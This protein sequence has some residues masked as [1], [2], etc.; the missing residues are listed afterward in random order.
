MPRSA[1]A[2]RPRA[3]TAPATSPWEARAGR[4][5]AVDFFAGAGGWTTAARALGVEVELS[6]NHWDVAVATHIANHP[7]TRHLCQDVNLVNWN[8]VPRT[9][10]FISSPSC[11][12]HAN[13]RGSDQPRHDTARATAWVVIDALTYLQPRM[14]VVEN[15]PEM[16]DDWILWDAWKLAVE[17]LGYKF[18]I[19]RLDAAEFG[20]AQHRER[21]FIV[22]TRV[23]KPPTIV[24][25]RLPL[26]PARAILDLDGG[27]WSP[28]DEHVEAT[29]ARA[30]A[31]RAAHGRTFVMPYYGSGSGLTGRSLDR[32]L[33]T[34]TTRDRW[35]IVRGRDMR[36]LHHGENGRA[37]GFPEGYKMAGDKKEIMQQFGNAV[38]PHQ[39]VEV[40][41]QMLGAAPGE[42]LRLAARNGLRCWADLG[43]A[44]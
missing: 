10:L 44:A 40:L 13:A 9:E 42:G 11:Q 29:I 22:G 36:M 33:G 31:G 3:R 38:V 23:G 20:V 34:I 27:E 14:F 16:V 1:P 30:A 17:R 24:S 43:A 4:T 37:M 7:N 25:P 6:A 2:S 15:V 18:T 28:V 35:A 12:G 41:A 5:H 39:G 19:N 8:V 21:V 32:P 26:V